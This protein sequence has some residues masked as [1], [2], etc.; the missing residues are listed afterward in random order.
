MTEPIVQVWNRA[1]P[2]L[3]KPMTDAPADL[4]AHFR[5]PENLFQVQ[6]YQYAN[7]HV[8]NATAFYQKR[9]FWQVPDDPTRS[10]EALGAVNAKLRPYYQLIRL[11]GED[12]E[13]FQLVLPFVPQDRQ[14]MV[15]WMA[16]SSDPGHYGDITVYR[17]P[18][19]RNID[20]PS[21]VFAR[22]NQDPTFSGQRTLLS[23]AGSD[24][25]FGDFLVIP[26]DDS[27]LYVQPVYVRSNQTAS[28]HELLTVA[29]VNGTGGNVFLANNL[30]DALQQAVQGQV[31]S[32]GGGQEP[33]GSGS[34]Q[35]R[36]QRLLA[37]AAA[38]F[39][40]AQTALTNGQLGTY[41]SEIDA[42]Q[43]AVQQAQQLLSSSGSGTGAS[44]SASPS[45]SPSVSPTAVP[46]ASASPSG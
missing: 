13:Q 34:V 28:I 3:F 31:P 26:I 44:P 19:G 46:T 40:N 42:A 8:T 24:V 45:V 43:Q 9:D 17:F 1:F 38:H 29:I 33:G 10:S 18:E 12:Q 27:F 16:A 41:Q 39:A 25:L 20:G 15:G 35:Q 32:G 23:Q 6:A 4:V 7:Y 21:Q 11:P 2:G 30:Q 36:V 14:N 5:Y 22:I 37:E